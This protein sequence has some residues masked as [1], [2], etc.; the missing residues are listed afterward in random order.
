MQKTKNFCKERESEGRQAKKLHTLNAGWGT[1]VGKTNKVIGRTNQSLEP[2][3]KSNS[4]FV[5]LE[6]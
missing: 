3:N 5:P 4:V 6:Q 1:E 2:G